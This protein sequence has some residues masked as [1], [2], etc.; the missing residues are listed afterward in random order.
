M[1]AIVA[2]FDYSMMSA[3][4]S[5]SGHCRMRFTAYGPT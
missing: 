1:N 2:P 3:G 4:I 5:A